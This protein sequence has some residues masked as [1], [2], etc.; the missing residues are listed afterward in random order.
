MK[1]KDV[2]VAVLAAAI[3]MLLVLPLLYHLNRKWGRLAN[4]VLDME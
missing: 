1:C 3:V 2:L 4:V